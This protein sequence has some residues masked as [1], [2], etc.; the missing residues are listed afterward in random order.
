MLS[1][2]YYLV[3]TTQG[4]DWPGLCLSKCNHVNNLPTF[5]IELN[6]MNDQWRFPVLQHFKHFKDLHY[7]LTLQ[8]TIHMGQIILET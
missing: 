6:S 2:I 4:C 1:F 8:E 3:S 7:L 5:Q